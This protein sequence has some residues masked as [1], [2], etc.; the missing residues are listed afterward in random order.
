MK[1]Q[2]GAEWKHNITLKI[3]MKEDINTIKQ[4]Q[5]A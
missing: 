4:D 5:Q 3:L 2:I 1:I